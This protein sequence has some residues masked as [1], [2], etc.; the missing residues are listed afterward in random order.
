MTTFTCPQCGG[1]NSQFQDCGCDS[2]EDQEADPEA[3]AAEH[4]A[5]VRNER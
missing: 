3:D 5:D 2:P 4:R 1:R